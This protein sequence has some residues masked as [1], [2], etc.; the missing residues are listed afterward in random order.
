[1]TNVAAAS[2][3]LHQIGALVL[4][5]F[6]SEDLTCIG[7]GLL[8]GQE[9]L[10][11][12]LAVFGC[13]LGIY[14]GDLGLWLIGRT[15]GRRVV[16]WRPLRRSLA[17]ASVER[18]GQWLDSRG[19]AALIAA[20]FMPGTRLPLYVAAGALGHRPW[21]FA[22][23]TFAAAA[24][25]TPLV[26]LLVATAGESAV[27]PLMRYLGGGWLAF[28]AAAMLLFALIRT[29]T[30]AATPV[31]RGRII[32]RVSRLWRW[33]FWPTWLFYLPLLPWIGILALRHR[34]LTVPTAANPGIPDGGVVG[35]SKFDILSRLPG[36]W[37]MPA[38]LIRAGDLEARM[39]QLRS[40]MDA[41]GWTFPVVL[42]PD[43][44]QRGAGVR[45]I[46]D[47]ASAA[48]YLRRR[49]APAIAQQYHPGPFEAGIFYYRLPGE[50]RGRI[51][52]IT[53]KHF[54]VL[55]GDGRS[56][57]EELIWRHPRFRMQAHTF[58]ARLDSAASGAGD[59]AGG[60][61]G[62]DART[63]ILSEGEALRLAHAGNHCQGTMFRDGGHLL[64]PALEETIDAISRRFAGF[65][66]G[67]FDVRY[68]RVDE[69]MAG[70]GFAIVEL[71]GVTSESTNIYDP[72]W[73]IW[74][75]WSLLMRQWAILFEIGAR[76][77]QRGA[78]ASSLWRLITD[79]RM[80][81]ARRDV[82]LV[83]D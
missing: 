36:E 56:T 26:V 58:L 73:S 38:A 71:N 43:A 74:R 24:V 40:V 83:A 45:L 37:V 63:T 6:A 35:E 66:F 2:D 18:W 48:E 12:A 62:K 28:P 76:N 54:P 52:S 69:F 44:G 15:I 21:R 81:Y 68:S 80:F 1:M 32:A 78:R 64:T 11:W 27:R 41:R 70:R 25:W 53:D 3:A 14:S 55:I 82:D 22:G 20:R 39:N 19:G 30:L 49:S 57:V 17:P 67:R 33:E 23:W 8:V 29:L 46:R 5:T 79:A 10:G 59:A 47:A 13:F 31:G 51:F 61:A 75:A 42:K 7:A 77:R 72:R 65:Y 4:G 9:R 34:G 60:N 50:P 16:I